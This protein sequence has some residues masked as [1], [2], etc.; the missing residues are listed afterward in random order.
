[1]GL[2]RTENPVI[3]L[4]AFAPVERVIRIC[5]LLGGVLLILGGTSECGHAQGIEEYLE[6]LYGENPHLAVLPDTA[7]WPYEEF[8]AVKDY[9]K[10]DSLLNECAAMKLAEGIDCETHVPFPLRFQGSVWFIRTEFDSIAGFSHS[11]FIDTTRFVGA[12]FPEGASFSGCR[13]SDSSSAWFNRADFSV[14]AAFGNTSFPGGASFFRVTFNTSC[15]ASFW[16]ANFKEHADFQYTQ[17]FGTASFKNAYFEHSSF[18]GASFGGGVSF[19]GAK[20]QRGG[21]FSRVELFDSADFSCVGARFVEGARFQYTRFGGYANFASSYFR[22]SV[23]FRDTKFAV[24]ASFA[25]VQFGD[26]DA[27]PN[28]DAVSFNQASIAGTLDF[29]HALIYA[30]LDFRDATFESKPRNRVIGTLDSGTIDITLEYMSDAGTP[31]AIFHNARI[32]DT[33]LV[34]TK[35]SWDPQYLDFTLAL[36]SE[37]T[38]PA[39][40]LFGPVDLRMQ[41]EKFKYLT[42]DTSLSYFEMKNIV[43]YLKQNS[44]AGPDYKKE[45]FE[46]DYLFADAVAYHR[47]S[48]KFGLYPAYHPWHWVKWFHCVSLGYGYRPF[49]IVWWMLGISVLY[50]ALYYRARHHLLSRNIGS[51]MK[52]L[53]DQNP[54]WGEDNWRSKPEAFYHCLWF[55]ITILLAIRIKPRLLTHFCPWEKRFV[56]SEYVI[57]L[58]LYAYFLLGSKAGSIGTTLIELFTG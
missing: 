32:L 18:D 21:N 55:S 1:M 52:R 50:A 2:G 31:W 58:S 25:D 27:I 42:F 23:V 11:T 26:A 51:Y 47:E 29:S 57:G 15:D 28:R 49:R 3:S 14:L 6:R 38:D 7:R 24:G 35:G 48:T 17:F 37:E 54:R 22:G 30:K 46:L 20:F 13:F 12:R 8:G 56:L 4:N 40:V 45:R 5:L 9:E 44:Y 10:R 33:I 43:E 19:D 41:V 36:F 34:G 39:I 53:A 16:Y